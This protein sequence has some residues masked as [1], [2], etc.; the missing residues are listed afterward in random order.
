[1]KVYDPMLLGLEG[2]QFPEKSVTQHLNNPFVDI[3]AIKVLCNKVGGGGVSFPENKHYEG[4]RFNVI[5][6]TK[7]WVGVKFPGK[8]VT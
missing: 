1:M 2:V 4:V 7:E 6:V 5:S 8:S 3:G